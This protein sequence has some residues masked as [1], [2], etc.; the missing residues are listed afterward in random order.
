MTCSLQIAI[1]LHLSM[2]RVLKSPT[3][4]FQPILASTG[5][6]NSTIEDQEF[7]HAYENN[8]TFLSLYLKCFVHF[9]WTPNPNFF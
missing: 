5:T 2:C 3:V 4:L 8:L 9:V 6:H 1:S 7:G